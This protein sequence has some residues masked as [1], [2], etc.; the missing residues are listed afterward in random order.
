ITGRPGSHGAVEW[1]VSWCLGDGFVN[2]YCNTIP[3]GDGGTHEQGLRVALL[4]GLRNYG[5][6]SGD[7]GIAGVVEIR[8]GWDPQPAAISF[9]QGYA[10]VDAATIENHRFGGDITRE[11]SSAGFGAR[12]TFQERATLKAE[13]AK[14]L[15]PRPFT[16]TGNGWRVFVSLSKE[17]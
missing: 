13:L 2:S 1:A 4:R 3:T 6:L 7:S 9:A 15:G 12:I 17:F 14:P 16:E 11:L 5:E 8:A 10:F